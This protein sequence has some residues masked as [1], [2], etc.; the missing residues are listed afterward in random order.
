MGSVGEEVVV[1][2]SVYILVLIIG[3]LTIVNSVIVHSI[4]MGKVLGMY[5]IGYYGE[6]TTMIIGEGVS[7]I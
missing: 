7:H 5:I 6:N 2:A 3:L 4:N 1:W